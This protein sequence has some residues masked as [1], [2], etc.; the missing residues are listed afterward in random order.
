[1]ITGYNT[2]VRHGE[3]VFHVQTED[4]GVS[5]PF[6]ESLVY[7]GG[8]VLASKRVSYAEILAAGKE[9]KEIVTLMD[10][11]HRTMIAAIRHG[12]L[13]AKLASLTAGRQTG[14]HPT[15]EAASVSMQSVTGHMVVQPPPA[16]SLDSGETVA[17]P[18]SAPV[19]SPTPT[20]YPTPTPAP[21][22][23]ATP[24]PNPIP[25]PIP[26]PIPERPA[27][28]ARPERTLD[29]VILEYLTSE[30]DQDQLVLMLEEERELVLGQSATLVLR[31][32]SSKSGQPM[33]GTQISV[34][35]IS[36]VIEP[37]VL[38]AGR[39]DDQG[40]LTLAFDIP[41]VSRGT[42]ALIINAVS[43]IGR[44]ELKHLL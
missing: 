40:S 39:T 4:K 43:S 29:Q 3:V 32:S 37:R 36:T 16:S 18:G 10:H 12:K 17:R 11:Q 35:M 30:A 38:A 27:A 24:V 33:V 14:Q 41:Q 23:A 28:P 2:D 21:A 20:P 6:I 22:P 44:A 7:V 9:E 19:S 5:N 42:S 8:Q 26:T 1:M 13:D 15:F 25:T 31:T 34:R